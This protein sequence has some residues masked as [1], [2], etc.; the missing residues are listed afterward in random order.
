[1]DGA[2]GF[3]HPVLV[4]SKTPGPTSVQVV[5]AASLIKLFWEALQGTRYRSSWEILSAHLG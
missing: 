5:S 4:V 1:M 2:G 3:T